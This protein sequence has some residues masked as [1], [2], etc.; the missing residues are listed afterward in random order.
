[1]F[2]KRLFVLIP[3]FVFVLWVAGCDSNEGGLDQDDLDEAT[4]SFNVTGD[5]TQTIEGTAAFAGGTNADGSEGFAFT[6]SSG[7]ASQT[8]AESVILVKNTA[9]RP[10]NGTYAVLDFIEG[11]FDTAGDNDFG[12]IFSFSASGS[13][14]TGSTV[15]GTLRVTDSDQNRIKG[16][17]NITASGNVINTTTGE[18]TPVNITI[19]GNFTA[20]GG[21]YSGL[22]GK[23]GP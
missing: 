1:M 13:V 18:S 19:S 4:F 2:M 23:A 6:F 17:V 21:I 7:T 20:S 8:T 14:A 12:G 11:D 15:A 9:E 10:G 5:V 22:P 3:L 16:S